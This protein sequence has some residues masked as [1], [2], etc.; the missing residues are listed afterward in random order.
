MTDSTDIEARLR[1]HVG[2]PGPL[3]LMLANYKSIHIISRA[4]A[5]ER[6]PRS[7]AL[8]LAGRAPRSLKKGSKM[9]KYKLVFVALASSRVFFHDRVCAGEPRDC[10]AK[11]RMYPRCLQ[12]LRRLHS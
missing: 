1:P 11:G 5:V 9:S 6:R 8:L 10:R 7:S 4:A 2:L 3:P 12:T